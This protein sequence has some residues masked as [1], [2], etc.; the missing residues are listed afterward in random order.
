M[1]NFYKEYTRNLTKPYLM[2][3]VENNGSSFTDVWPIASN[4]K[5]DLNSLHKKVTN[6]TSFKF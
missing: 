2:Q 6:T 4:L 1:F 5:N 3:R